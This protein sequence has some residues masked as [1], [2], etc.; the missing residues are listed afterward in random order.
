MVCTLSRTCHT[1]VKTLLR[2]KGKVQ[3][4]IPLPTHTPGPLLFC[5]VAYD[6][7]TR[8]WSWSSETKILQSLQHLF[9]VASNWDQGHW[10]S[11]PPV[12]LEPSVEVKARRRLVTVDINILSV[13]FI[14]HPPLVFP[15]HLQFL[16]LSRN[17][18]TLHWIKNGLS[19]VWNL[20]LL[21]LIKL[22]SYFWL[23]IASQQGKILLALAIIYLGS[24]CSLI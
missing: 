13:N 14:S 5:S 2:K 8:W 12:S 18:I 19:S 3:V 10:T 20:S 24:I 4:S 15:M 23:L 1:S 9:S 7:A 16:G 21:I 6:W 11:Q 22:H 17:A